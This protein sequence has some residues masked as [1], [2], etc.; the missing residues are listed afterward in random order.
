[1]VNTK[2]FECKVCFKVFGKKANLARHAKSHQKG[3]HLVTKAMKKSKRSVEKDEE[4]FVCDICSETYATK[5]ELEV[6][7]LDHLHDGT[8]EAVQVFKENV[9]KLKV[10]SYTCDICNKTFPTKFKLLRHEYIHMTIKPFPCEKCGRRF[11][12]KDH[13]QVHYRLHTGEKICYCLEC[14]QGFNTTTALHRHIARLHAADRRTYLCAECDLEFAFKSQLKR[15]YDCTHRLS[16]TCEFCGNI[17]SS[18]DALYRHLRKHILTEPYVCLMCSTMFE[19]TTELSQHQCCPMVDDPCKVVVRVTLPDLI[20]LD[21]EMDPVDEKYAQK[22]QKKF[23]NRGRKPKFPS[24]P[25]SEVSGPANLSASGFHCRFCEKEFATEADKLAHEMIHTDGYENTTCSIC[26]VKCSTTGKLVRHMRTHVGENGFKCKFCPKAFP[27]NDYLQRHMFNAHTTDEETC[28]FCFQFC[29]TPEGLKEHLRVHADPK[30]VEA[31][32]CDSCDIYF[33]QYS[34]LQDHNANIH[35]SRDSLKCN[36]CHQTFSSRVLL[37]N[38]KLECAQLWQVPELINDEERLINVDPEVPASTTFHFCEMCDAVFSSYLDKIRH[39]KVIHKP[40]FYT[41]ELCPCKF[42]SSLALRNHRIAVHNDNALRREVIQF[43]MQ[44]QL[45]SQMKK[46][47]AANHEILNPEVQQEEKIQCMLCDETFSTVNKL[48]QH[49]RD[50]EDN[51]I[52]EVGVHEG[53]TEE[54]EV[55]IAHVTA[56]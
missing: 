28:P 2:R 41:C 30:D 1:M 13:L 15:H 52:V 47:T 24:L 16:F 43:R 38:H 36:Y 48:T 39:L 46:Y 33:S 3:H 44:K 35:F 42:V 17:S 8:T 4:E 10:R 25:R 5:S 18:E 37:T 50:H 29:H 53:E 14:G 32:F 31:H 34:E 27:C 23:D 45:Q 55:S 11:S 19:T 54:K 49:L 51:M 20:G 56:N 7:E 22:L 26:K 6:H 9:K 40:A 12:R 21:Y